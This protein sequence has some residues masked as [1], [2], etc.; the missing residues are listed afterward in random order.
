[1]IAGK[2]KKDWVEVTL[3]AIDRIVPAKRQT[4]EVHSNRPVMD[5]IFRLGQA[6]PPNSGLRSRRRGTETEANEIWWADLS[7]AAKLRSVLIVTRLS[8]VSFFRP[9]RGVCRGPGRE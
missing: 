1:M 9:V 5:A 4:G 3:A 7:Q 6:Y 8:V 2:E